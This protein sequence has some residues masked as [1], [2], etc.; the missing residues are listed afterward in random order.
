[1]VKTFISAILLLILSAGISFGQQTQKH[2][3]NTGSEKQTDRASGK[4]LII[5]D[6][7]INP[8]CDP[9][10]I[11]GLVRT[12]YKG[13]EA[14]F[15]SPG[16]SSY[17]LYG[18][19][20][21]YRLFKSAL[22]AMAAQNKR[23]DMIIINGDFLSHNFGSSFKQSTGIESQD[24]M[25][26]FTRKTISFV[27]L[28]FKKYFPATPI[29]PVLGN[30]DDFCGDY[31]IQPSGPFLSFFAEQSESLL[32]NVDHPGFNESF[33]RG[34]YYFGFMPWD[35]SQVF[36]G[37]NTIFFSA[38]Y[39]NTCNPSDKTEPGWDEFRWL[40]ET[41][42]WCETNHKKVWLSYHI[43]P[44][45]DVYASL[46]SGGKCD[47]IITGMWK[48][49][50]NDSFLALVSR[51]SNIIKANLAGHTHM[52]DFRLIGSGRTAN[53]FV[54]ITPAVSPMFGNNPAFQEVTWDTHTMEFINSET[55]K[56]KGL[57]FPGM[58]VWEP[59]YNYRKIY[60]IKS[61]DANSLLSVWDKIGADSVT[62]YDY[63]KY[64]YVS[65]PGKFPI[66]WHA[67][68]CGIRNLTIQGFRKC[69]CG[70]Y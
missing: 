50:Y 35:N 62:R 26:S 59:E 41:L 54:H 11:K 14:L 47:S 16:D 20:T 15:E 55:Y 42:A 44:G 39:V 51:Y 69:Q 10:I 57:S 49:S 6:V 13:W 40:K 70:K 12:D 18:S 32:H 58:N 66:P 46:Y 27:F 25:Q 9:Q 2:K 29:L 23:P 4:L 21:Y 5:S 33:S 67:Y 45:I 34:G 22:K 38:K 56:F 52:D 31:H 19:D 30:N 48:E 43:P 28:M 64:Y 63:M 53:S 3:A 60:G 7:H 68:W 37:L 24:S 36:I 1:M 17:G 65:H 8:F 61:I